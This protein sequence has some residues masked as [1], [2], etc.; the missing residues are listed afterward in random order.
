MPLFGSI[1]W[2]LLKFATLYLRNFSLGISCFSFICSQLAS[3]LILVKFRGSGNKLLESIFAGFRN[4]YT[5]KLAARLL[6]EMSQCEI[7]PLFNC[8]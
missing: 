5:F 3:Q 8:T 4:S 6:W 2:K 7:R 1:W